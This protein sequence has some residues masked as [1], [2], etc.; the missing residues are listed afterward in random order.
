MIVFAEKEQLAHESSTFHCAI[1]QN[2]CDNCDHIKIANR[3]KD[4][5]AEGVHI[6]V[7]LRIPVHP[8][9]ALDVLAYLTNHK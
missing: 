9:D 6:W 3:R 8:L 5:L 1:I 7:S 2:D 4:I